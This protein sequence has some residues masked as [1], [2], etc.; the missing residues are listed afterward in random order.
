MT[1]QGG[2]IAN[3]RAPE[4]RLDELR[5]CLPALAMSGDE[6]PE[7]RRKALR[8]FPAMTETVEDPM[9]LSRGHR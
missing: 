1:T 2:S 8:R 6:L 7:V 3:W 5:D 9:G 4:E